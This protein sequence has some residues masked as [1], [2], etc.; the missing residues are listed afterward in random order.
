MVELSRLCE[1]NRRGK[2]IWDIDDDDNAGNK[3]ERE[4][5]SPKEESLACPTYVCIICCGQSRRSAPNP[6]P[7]KAK[8]TLTQPKPQP[9]T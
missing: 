7:H 2:R 3:L 4:S 8:G 1:P 5:L 6:P 9:M